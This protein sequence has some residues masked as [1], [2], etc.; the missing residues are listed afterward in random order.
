[1]RTFLALLL[2]SSVGNARDGLNNF[3][4]IQ[5]VN[6]A[7][8]KKYGKVPLKNKRQTYEAYKLLILEAEVDSISKV[9]EG[10]YESRR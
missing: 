10:K 4:D 8:Q 7:I 3:L 6:L 5:Q 9:R 1:M 2:C